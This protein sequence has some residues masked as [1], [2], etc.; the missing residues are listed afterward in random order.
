[1]TIVGLRNKF[2]VN[3]SNIGT[4]TYEQLEQVQ[5]YLLSKF[6]YVT[7]EVQFEKIDYWDTQ[8]FDKLL[9]YDKFEGDCDDFGYCVIEL[10]HKVFELPKQDIYRVS[11]KVETGGGHFVAWIKAA[12]GYT[13]QLE[14]RIRVPRSIKFMVD[15]G[16]TYMHYSSM[17]H[18]DM[19]Y[20]ANIKVK[21]LVLETPPNL[22]A[23]RSIFTVRKALA[24]EKSKSLQV[25]WF[26]VMLGFF[27]TLMPFLQNNEGYLEKILSAESVG[28]VMILLGF[29]TIFL[30]TI[31]N[32]DISLKG[33]QDVDLS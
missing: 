32:K 28:V 17:K 23:D 27:S 1:M 7:D 10:C 9:R 4:V 21:A 18:T 33:A 20:D 30:R 12:D 31:T 25:G 11:C 26:Q 22:K 14:N 6:T 8:A 13:Y 3:S 29:I 24:V 2:G 16:Y 19:W 5:S 15:F